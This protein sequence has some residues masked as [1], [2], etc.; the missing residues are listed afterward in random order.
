M[1]RPLGHS[2]GETRRTARAEFRL[3]RNARSAADATRRAS[4]LR[5]HGLRA[6]PVGRG[7][8]GGARG[9]AGGVAARRGRG[10]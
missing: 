5:V 3:G 9:G 6:R 1:F 10:I 8:S 7:A 2:F 4:L